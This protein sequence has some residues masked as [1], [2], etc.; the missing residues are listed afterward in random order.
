MVRVTLEQSVIRRC[1]AAMDYCED[2]DARKGMEAL[3]DLW[4]EP[5]PE[6]QGELRAEV[7]L[8]VG[9]VRFSN[10]IAG[11]ATHEHGKDSL[12]ESQRI[13]TELNNPKADLATVWLAN[14]YL[15]QGAEQEALL[16]LD[17]VL[18]RAA[19]S[20]TMVSASISKA[21]LLTE[22]S[23]FYEALNVLNAIQGMVDEQRPSVRGKFHTQRGLVLR[24]L[25]QTDRA[26]Q[27]YEAARYSF[28]IAG[29]LRFQAA[30]LNNLAY[31]QRIKKQFAEAHVYADLA[32]DILTSLDDK[33]F[34]AQTKDTKAGVYLDEGK[35]DE[36]LTQAT[37]AAR[38]LTGDDKCWLPDILTTRGKILARQKSDK[39]KGSFLRA[40]HEAETEGNC[41]QAANAY[42]T[43]I[44]ELVLPVKERAEFYRRAD[45]FSVDADRL[46]S[47]AA[48]IIN[49]IHPPREK[50]N[51]ETE[52]EEI[53]TALTSCKGCVEQA[54]R[55][56]GL[57]GPGLARKLET[58]H[59]P[60]LPLRNKKRTR[61]TS[62]FRK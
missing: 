45:S 11:N 35:L 2:S 9:A 42:L 53:R 36:A 18:G 30:I 48:K 38:L 46:R 21:F 26:F 20:A 50:R 22:G 29:N 56:L 15:R 33:A 58:D 31:L 3:G 10:A 47:C 7:L 39:A 12:G 41:S 25:G 5:G 17:N 16:L 51:K 13:F 37:D 23:R 34:L 14:A 61:R 43:M 4:P 40:V 57:S 19:E 44:E 62:L 24:K 54:A 60:L 1:R 49:D 59:R 32:V 6:I 55:M 8:A 52:R 27:E 28:E